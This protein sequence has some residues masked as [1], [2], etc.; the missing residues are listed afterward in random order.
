MQ[1]LR[2][3]EDVIKENDIPARDRLFGTLGVATRV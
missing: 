2:P 1:F 3:Q